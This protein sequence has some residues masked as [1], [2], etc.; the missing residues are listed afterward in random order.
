MMLRAM[1]GNGVRIG[2]VLI[3][4]ATQLRPTR[5]GRAKAQAGWCGVVIGTAILTTCGWLSATTTLRFIGP[6]AAG[7]DVCQDRLN[8]P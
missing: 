3:T 8:Y 7:F 1:F 6:T 2:M 5:W 4:T